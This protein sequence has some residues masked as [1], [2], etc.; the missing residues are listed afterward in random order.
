MENVKRTKRTS[1][2]SYINAA[3]GIMVEKLR[4]KAV[5]TYILQKSFEKISYELIKSYFNTRMQ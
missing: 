5:T 1:I 4:E 2:T 3:V